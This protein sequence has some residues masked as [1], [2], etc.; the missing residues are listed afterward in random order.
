MKKFIEFT[1]S[2]IKAGSLPPLI[3][4]VIH[5]IASRGFHAYHHYPLLDVPMHFIGGVVIC[6]F[7]W[8]ASKARHTELFL[9]THT[10]FSLFVI[11]MALTASATVLWEFAEWTRDTVFGGTAQV[12]ITDTMGDMF[13]GLLGGSIVALVAAKKHIRD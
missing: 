2:S 11:L 6:Y 3:V 5:V 8:C 10:R 12:S 7:F 4:F 9:G 13:L 1:L